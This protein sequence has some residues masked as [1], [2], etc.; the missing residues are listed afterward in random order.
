MTET[1]ESDFRAAAQWFARVELDQG[2]AAARAG[3]EAWFA[4]HP[5]N[6]LRYAEVAAAWG[7]GYALGPGVGSAPSHRS[8]SALRAWIAGAAFAPLLLLAL[9]WGPQWLLRIESD[10]LGTSGEQRELALADGSRLVLDGDSAVAIDLAPDARRVEVLRGAVF[11]DVAHD[12]TRPFSIVAGSLSA[13][14]LGTAFGVTLGAER[15]EVAVSEGTVEVR[16]DAES[17]P[18]RL[19]AGQVFAWQPDFGRIDRPGAADSALGWR[20]GALVFE[21][22]PLAEALARIDRHLPERVVLIGGAKAQ[23]P[24]TGVFP[25]NAAHAAVDDLARLNGLEVAR[26]PGVALILR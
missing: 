15:I 21:N 20:R 4:Q 2:D 5:D 17:A 26:I 10:A 23:T 9:L 1:R 7:A 18:A 24:V 3:L 14:A 11:V 16:A 12:H 25:T 22:L 6:R 19:S 13:T 8:R